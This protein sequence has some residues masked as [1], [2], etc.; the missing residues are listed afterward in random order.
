[1][2][3]SDKIHH[4]G[5]FGF[6][7]RTI[8]NTNVK[9]SYCRV[10]IQTTNWLDPSNLLV[11]AAPFMFLFHCISHL[12]LL[13][14]PKCSNMYKKL[15][16]TQAFWGNWLFVLISINFQLLIFRQYYKTHVTNIHQSQ[17]QH[18]HLLWQQTIKNTYSFNKIKWTAAGF[19]IHSLTC[20]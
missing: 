17:N 16:I 19:I 9:I 4:I 11:T 14:F 7:A 5:S 2:K 18:F 1:M 20:F 3:L 10:P 13:R 6:K 15:A 12:V 8:L